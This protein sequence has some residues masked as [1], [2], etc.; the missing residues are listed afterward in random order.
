MI[1][2]V[3]ATNSSNYFASTVSILMQSDGLRRDRPQSARRLAPDDQITIIVKPTSSIFS[4]V[5]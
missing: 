3:D 4:M 1:L 5:S 2:Q